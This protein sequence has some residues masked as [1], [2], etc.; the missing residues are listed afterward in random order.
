M[1]VTKMTYLSERFNQEDFKNMMKDYNYGF[2]SEPDSGKTT[3]II[4]HLIPLAE[5]ENKT[6]LFLYPRTAIG[7]Q[8]KFK[9]SSNVIEFQTYQALENLIKNNV[10]LPKY[11]FIVCDE[12]HYFVDDSDFN[13]D[14][15]LS[16]DFIDN[17]RDSIKILL[18]GTPEPLQYVNFKKPIIVMSTVNYSN[19]NVEIVFLSRTT[20]L[21]EQELKSE[22]EKGNQSIVFSSSATKAYEMSQEFISYNPFFISSKGNKSFKHKNDENIRDKIINE[23]KSERSVGFMTSAMNTG[24]NFNEDIKNV[25]ILG[26]PSSVD[27]R[28]SVGRVRKGN[29][30]RKVRLYLQ[31]PFGQAIR[32]KCESM[33]NDLEYFDLGIYE[34]QQKYGR[35]KYPRFIWTD[36]DKNNKD[37]AHIKINQLRLAKLKSDLSDFAT[38]S[39]DTVGTYRR[40]IEKYYPST[41]I[42]WLK[43]S[44]KGI[45]EY[46]IDNEGNYLLK[47]DQNK[48]KEIFKENGITSKSGTVGPKIIKDYLYQKK[49]YSL[50]QPSKMIEGKKQR[51]WQFKKL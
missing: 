36:P 17:S 25:I 29:E 28:Q 31:V 20:K 16:F 5:K 30:D 19:H 15:D 3:M 47:D 48:V 8:L 11:D 21:I 37:I 27:I 23:E 33:K 50:E 4:K 40:M 22:L 24:I 49:E 35:N 7:E 51:V 18:T 38:M 14:T 39:S 6:I 44:L 46:L 41:E 34:W 42:Y 9:T 32:A 12:A 1:E 13:I 43:E 10:I 2:W 45:E 26:S